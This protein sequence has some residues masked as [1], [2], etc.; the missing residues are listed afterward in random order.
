[1]NENTWRPTAS[2]ETLK[3]RS[4]FI[5]KIREFFRERDVLEVETPILS[6]A[7]VT[8]PYI[9]SVEVPMGESKVYMQTSPEF[10]IKRL[11]AAGI[12]SVYEICKSFRYGE[13]GQHHNPEF[14]MIEWY[15][16]GFSLSDLMDEMDD[17][18]QF[19]LNTEKA[20]RFSYKQVFEKYLSINP[21]LASAIELR[22]CAHQYGISDV[23]GT[24]VEDRDVWLQLLMSDY[25]ELRIGK[26]TPTFIYDYPS[27]QSALARLK[28]DGG[29]KVAERFEVYFKG[30]ELANGFHELADSD[31]QRSRFEDDLIKRK[32]LGCPEVKIDENFLSALAHGLPDCSG[33]ALGLDRLF[34]L[35]LGKESIGEVMSFTF[36]VS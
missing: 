6:H 8:D 27:S 9:Q 18:F 14:T 13:V 5:N 34:M 1:M 26:S 23:D 10:A 21:H 3:A 29:V 15:R 28:D 2:I 33:V 19:L 12:G 36:D 35:A 22:I 7:T 20:E 16:I 30:M 24:D 11:L 31:E 4:E 32:K 25:I 17:L